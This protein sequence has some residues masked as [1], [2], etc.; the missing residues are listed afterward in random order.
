MQTIKV[1]KEYTIEEVRDEFSDKVDL[2]KD[3]L[4][5][6]CQDLDNV[7][8]SLRLKVLNMPNIRDNI[9]VARRELFMVDQALE[10]ISKNITMM[11]AENAS[12]S[13]ELNEEGQDE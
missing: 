1:N 3:E 8:H 2:V 9:N 10:S 5:R 4:E 7:N 13:P 6:L 12:P 11:L